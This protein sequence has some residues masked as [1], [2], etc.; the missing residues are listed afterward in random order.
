MKKLIDIALAAGVAV[1]LCGCAGQQEPQ[2]ST[3]SDHYLSVARQDGVSLLEAAQWVRSIGIE[4]VD[5]RITLTDEQM[6]D[7]IAAGIKPAVLFLT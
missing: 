6:A 1:A 3:F 7:F 4:G 2:F 5:A